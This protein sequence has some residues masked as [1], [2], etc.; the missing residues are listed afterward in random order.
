MRNALFRKLFLS[1][2]YFTISIRKREDS[3]LL[4][5]PYFHSDYTVPSTREYWCADPFF[6]EDGNRT[7]LFYEKVHGDLGS[8]EVAEIQRDCTLSEPML[9]FGGSSHY[10]YPYV[11]RKDG[12]WYMIPESSALNEVSLYKASNF[13]TGWVKTA[14]LLNSP[15]VDT[16]V[17]QE[18]GQWYLLS[19]LPTP[20]SERVTPMAF[21]MNGIDL[22]PLRWEYYDPLRVRGAGMP[23]RYEGKLVRPVQVSTDQRYGDQVLFVQ[24]ELS[25]TSYRETPLTALVP[26]AVKASGVFFD[27]LHTY[28][29]SSHFEVIDLRCGAFNPGKPFQRLAEKLKK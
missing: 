4:A 2:S 19:F 12:K 15:A 6:A 13:P 29:T 27:G 24:M 17:F 9:L 1:G 8:I 20:G 21:R 11:F 18:N 14:V 23:F 5:N 22:V 25:D 3:M 26:E 7:F 28:N 16:T 10:S